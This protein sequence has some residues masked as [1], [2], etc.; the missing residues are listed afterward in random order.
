MKVPSPGIPPSQPMG[1][2]KAGPD[3]AAA[4]SGAIWLSPSA[5][6][7]PTS[8]LGESFMMAVLC[9]AYQATISGMFSSNPPGTKILS[10]PE[11]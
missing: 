7:A 8:D 10:R 1:R 9:Y 3:S 4:G 6:A 2:V 5:A 11:R